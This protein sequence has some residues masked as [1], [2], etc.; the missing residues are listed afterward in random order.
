MLGL[1]RIFLFYNSQF[2]NVTFHSIY[3]QT[4]V[5]LT[6]VELYINSTAE[7]SWNAWSGISQPCVKI[8]SLFMTK[9]LKTCTREDVVL[10]R[11]FSFL[12]IQD[13]NV[14][15]CILDIT[16][17]RVFPRFYRKSPHVNHYFTKSLHLLDDFRLLTVL[18]QNVDKFSKHFVSLNQ[19]LR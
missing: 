6:C 16:S 4:W 2:I 11:Y 17:F 7:K 12:F 18:E 5:S 1:I 8:V 3:T 19:I 9:M 15:L 13:S 14:P 10:I